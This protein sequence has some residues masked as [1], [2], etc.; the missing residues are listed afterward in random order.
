[1]KALPKVELHLHLEGAAPPG[2]IREMAAEKGVDTSGIFDAEGAYHYKDFQ[3]FL[4]VYEA[5]TRVLR[6]PEDYARLTTAVLQRSAAEGILYT[7]AFLSPDFC[8]GRDV[9]AWREYVAAMR[10]A[11]AVV[12]G[13]EM[14]GVVT[15]IRHFGPEKAVETAICAAETAGGFIT[16][17]GMGGDEGRYAPADFAP[18]YHRAREAG[19]GLTVHAG[20]FGGPE[21]VRAALDALAPVRI[22]HGVRAVEDPALVERLAAEG[23]V[24]EVCPRSNVVLGIYTNVASH[25]VERLRRA[26]VPVTVSTDDPPFFHTTLS[27]EYDALAGA[28]GWTG[29]TFRE[30]NRTAIRAAFCDGATRARI[31]EHLE[32]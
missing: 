6:T 17:F 23:I 26:G 9:G 20:E 8:G 31:L 11:A 22:G 15:C 2:L 32:A 24:L 10:E 16:G 29:D 7:E 27:Q 18:A 25:P 21:S 1:M 5:A 28:F 14:R 3:G 13:I 4:Q 30:I 19:L 12:P